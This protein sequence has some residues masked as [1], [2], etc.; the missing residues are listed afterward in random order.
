M[1]TQLLRAALR[2]NSRA[3]DEASD[4]QEALERVRRCRVELDEE[5][6]AGLEPD[7]VP[8]VLARQ[9]CYDVAL[10]RMARSVGIET[11]PSRFDRPGRERARLEQA[12]RDL[13]L[14]PTAAR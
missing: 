10:L 3:A 11:D 12:F 13:G 6:P 5:V 4:R 14:D 2:H 8:I 1:Y 7:T 9:V